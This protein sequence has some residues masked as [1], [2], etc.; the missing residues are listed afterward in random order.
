MRPP[1]PCPCPNL[2]A[3][4]A[5]GRWHIEGEPPRER[6]SGRGGPGGR[7]GLLMAPRRARTPS[8]RIPALSRRAR[9]GS[10]HHVPPF[11]LSSCRSDATALWC[12]SR[13]SSSAASRTTTAASS[14]GVAAC[15]V[16]RSS[17]WMAC[18]FGPTSDL[19]S[20]RRCSRRA[21]LSSTSP[22]AA[23]KYDRDNRARGVMISV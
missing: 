19:P 14:S 3:I 20:S 6:G 2:P 8:T 4:R 15:V 22:P 5:Q 12:Q 17:P 16:V 1:C 10:H 18:G 9:V 23:R 13:S 11:V 7:S 21:A